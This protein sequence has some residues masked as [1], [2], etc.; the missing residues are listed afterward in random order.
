MTQGKQIQTSR[1][2]VGKERVMC[3]YGIRYRDND[4]IGENNNTPEPQPAP[5]EEVAAP[6]S[7]SYVDAVEAKRKREKIANKIKDAMNGIETMTKVIEPEAA[8]MKMQAFMK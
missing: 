7:A 4:D 5:I 2:T 6:M 3:Y 8:Q 1:R